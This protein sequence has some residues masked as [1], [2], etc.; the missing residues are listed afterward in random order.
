MLVS[1]VQKVYIP[2]YLYYVLIS[3]VDCIQKKSWTPWLTMPCRIWYVSLLKSTQKTTFVK[4]VDRLELTTLLHILIDDFQMI[5]WY[6]GGKDQSALNYPPPSFLVLSILYAL[7]PSL[8]PS[9]EA[10]LCH[11]SRSPAAFTPF[12]LYL[13]SLYQRSR[14]ISLQ[15]QF[16]GTTVYLP[17]LLSWTAVSTYCYR[18][19]SLA[20]P[21]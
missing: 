13:S 7:Q 18:C 4:P 15:R 9:L 21:S 1:I 17:N 6:W 12:C 11:H 19:E 14:A 20:V 10:L 5:I 8:A 3:I 2:T 16:H